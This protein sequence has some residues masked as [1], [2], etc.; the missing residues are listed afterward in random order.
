MT[1]PPKSAGSSRFAAIV[2][3]GLLLIAGCRRPPIPP[4]PSDQTPKTR[5]VLITIRTTLQPANQAW[6]HRIVIADGR[7]RSMN[8]TD[9]WRL[10]DFTHETVTFVDEI[11]KTSR[12]EPFAS[13]LARHHKEIARALPEGAREAQFFRAG[14]K[15]SIAGVEAS[16]WVLRIGA[17]ERHLWIGRHPLIPDDLFA[18]LEASGSASPQLPGLARPAQEAFLKIAGFPMADVA[19]LPFGRAKLLV[20]KSVTAIE[21]RDVPQSWFNVPAADRAAPASSVSPE[22][23]QGAAQK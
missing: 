17:Y 12:A 16:E 7:A 15:R 9:R 11:G 13:I 2:F 1:N 18:I 19:T 21:Q 8:E 20:D 5:A 14:G 3:P 6:T 23:G 4:H 22:K 10:I